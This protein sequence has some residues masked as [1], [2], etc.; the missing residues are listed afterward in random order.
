MLLASASLFPLTNHVY[1]GTCTASSVNVHQKSSDDCCTIFCTYIV[2]AHL[3]HHIYAPMRANYVFFLGELSNLFV[4][5]ASGDGTLHIRNNTRVVF[6]NQALN[7][8]C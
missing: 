2:L 3:K 5:V 6:L 4:F 8:C 7:M 1:L